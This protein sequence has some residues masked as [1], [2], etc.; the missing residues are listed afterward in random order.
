MRCLSSTTVACSKTSSTSL[1]MTKVPFSS[2]DCCGFDAAGGATAAPDWDWR[3]RRG[4][5]GLG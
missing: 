2:G 3:L 5:L 1:R 4:R